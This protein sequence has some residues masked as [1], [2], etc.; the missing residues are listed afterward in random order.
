MQPNPAEV[1][2]FSQMNTLQ[3]NIPELRIRGEQ[4]DYSASRIINE[5]EIDASFFDD[6]ARSLVFAAAADRHAKVLDAG[7]QATEQDREF[8]ESVLT[9]LTYKY[10]PIT[11]VYTSEIEGSYNTMSDSGTA[12]VLDRYTDRQLSA[13]LDRAIKQDGLLTAS[14]AKLGITPDNETPFE[15]RVLSIDSGGKNSFPLEMDGPEELVHKQRLEAR[16][17]Q[18]A[19]ELGVDG[20][21]PPAW[22]KAIDGKMVMC[23]SAP[24]AEKIL[25]PS[26]AFSKKKYGLK[27]Y[28]YDFA[29]IVHE[30]VH[31][32]GG[33]NLDG[34]LNFGMNL[35]E[36]RAEH[37]SGNKL[38]YRDI[39]WFFKDIATLTGISVA[40]IIQD[41]PAGDKPEDVYA[42]LARTLGVETMLEVLLAAPNN[43]P[44]QWGNSFLRSAIEYIG[45]YDGVLRRIYD[46]QVTVGKSKEVDDRV[47]ARALTLKKIIGNS[48]DN[49]LWNDN[50]Q[51]GL[52][53]VTDLVNAKAEEL[54]I[55]EP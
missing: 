47:T 22:T 30:Y 13:A 48:P 35:E 41:Y 32:Q 42:T 11:S 23:V 51:F 6:P 9:M 19:S 3:V 12:A 7:E 18:M 5:L 31:T 14:K 53:V 36:L 55:K 4:I 28:E 50:R 54:G 26:L 1:A 21:L 46:H 40:D 15:V 44:D 45:G 27:D 29:S 43:Y 20:K 39:K 25:Q 34:G 33:L 2:F 38:G 17:K 16:A 24:L 37:L 8:V 52:N 49:W 10:S